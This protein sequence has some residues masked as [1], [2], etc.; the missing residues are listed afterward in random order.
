MSTVIYFPYLYMGRTEEVLFGDVK[1]W[2]LDRRAQEYIPDE[3]LRNKVTALLHANKRSNTPIPGI[4]VVTIN[5]TTVFE[6]TT[7]DTFKRID[8][9]RILVF[10]AVLAKN[11]TLIDWSDP[12]A[13]HTVR[14]SENCATVFQNFNESEYTSERT[15]VIVAM[16]IGGYTIG[17]TT[18]PI[19]SY[20]PSPMDLRLDLEFINDLLRLKLLRP[21][22]YRQILLAGEAMFDS[23]HNDNYVSHNSRILNQARAIEILFKLSGNSTQKQREYLKTKVERYIT[24]PEDK[25]LTYWSERGRGSKEKEK[26]SR[27]VKWADQFYTLRN[28]IIHG[29]VIGATNFAFDGKQRHIDITP[30]FFILGLKKELNRAF[31][32]EKYFDQIVWKGGTNAYGNFTGFFYEDRTLY[33][34]ILRNLRRSNNGYALRN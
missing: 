2:N 30:M 28:H 10:L 16:N 1:I 34:T 5:E 18:Y 11:V 7:V 22:R 29:D 24:L 21:T 31:R 9:V 32:I 26:R 23:Y 14:T 3:P 6:S 13:G 33:G 19:P 12:N 15:G 27:K 25:V 20:V 8:E 4:G 17:E